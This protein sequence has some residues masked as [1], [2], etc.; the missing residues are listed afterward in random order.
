MAVF[1]KRFLCVLFVFAFYGAFSQ[2][3]LPDPEGLKGTHPSDCQRSTPTDIID[4]KVFPSNKFLLAKDSMNGY[5]WVSFS[6][7]DKLLVINCGCTDY[8]LVFQFTTSRYSADTTQYKYWFPTAVILMDEASP[9]LAGIPINVQQGLDTLSSFITHYP[10]SLKLNHPIIY[11][12]D[13]YIP[14]DTKNDPNALADFLA[15]YPHI[16]VSRIEK[17]SNGKYMV[18]VYVTMA[19]S[20]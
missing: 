20:M 12:Y 6:N 18:E 17:L 3:N 14:D 1:T 13:H 2:Q 4:N 16:F 9:G 11:N 5:N 8:T 10:D 15:M 19:L 7:G